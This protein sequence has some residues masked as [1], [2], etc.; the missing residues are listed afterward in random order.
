M[1]RFMIVFAM[2]VKV[3][4]NL[5]RI[6]IPSIVPYCFAPALQGSRFLRTSAPTMDQANAGFSA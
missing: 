5:L 6:L 4:T 3:I 2:P 1:I